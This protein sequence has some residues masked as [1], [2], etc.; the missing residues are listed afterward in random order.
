LAVLE[1]LSDCAKMHDIAF[2][3]ALAVILAAAIMFLL[4]SCFSQVSNSANATIITIEDSREVGLNKSV[5][6]LQR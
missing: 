6:F 5:A 1:G 3:L 2:K 4:A